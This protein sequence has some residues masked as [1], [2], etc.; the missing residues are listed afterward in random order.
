MANE[1][2]GHLSFM[3][4]FV[5]L[6]PDAIDLQ[7]ESYSLIH[8]KTTSFGIAQGLV[9]HERSAGYQPFKGLAEGV[10]FEPTVLSYNGFQDRRLK[11]LGHPSLLDPGGSRN[12]LPVGS[13]NR[14]CNRQPNPRVFN[15]FV[16]QYI[17]KIRFAKRKVWEFPRR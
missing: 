13:A 1:A 3:I 2:L 16:G 15:G 14:F 5:C 9:R 10:G 17:T 6:Y 11:P 7:N 12:P 8:F 4:Y